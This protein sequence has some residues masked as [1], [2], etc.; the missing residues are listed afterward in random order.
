MKFRSVK[1]LKWVLKAGTIVGLCVL[2]TKVATGYA[3]PVP[4]PGM[5]AAHAQS[6]QHRDRRHMHVRNWA[7]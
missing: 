4:G 6:M 7:L 1:G 5:P 2:I 3:R